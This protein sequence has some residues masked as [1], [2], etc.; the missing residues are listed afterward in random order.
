MT[1]EEIQTVSFFQAYFW[2]CT[3]LERAGYSR[4]QAAALIVRLLRDFAT[5]EQLEA[6]LKQS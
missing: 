6:A 2:I 3:G 5:P 1:P 4:E